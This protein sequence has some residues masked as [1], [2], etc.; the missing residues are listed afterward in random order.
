MS[1]KFNDVE[2]PDLT[3]Y[4]HFIF[5]PSLSSGYYGNFMRKDFK[6]RNG[7]P[8]RYNSEDF[9]ELYRY[10]NFLITA[11]HW[12][13]KATME[14]G[15]PE[16]FGFKTLQSGGKDL[17]MGDS[18]GFQIA[19]GTKPFNQE[20]VEDTY[21]WLNNNVDVAVNLDIPPRLTYLGKFESCLEQSVKNFTYFAEQK[22]RK[23]LFLNVLQGGDWN[24][25]AHWYSKVSGFDFDGWC[26]GSAIGNVKTLFEAF[27]VL[28]EGKEHLNPNNKFVHI[29]GTT[30]PLDMWI[31]AVF[32]LEM[33]KAGFQGVVSI[34]SS[35]PSML[36]AFG[37]TYSNYNWIKES[38]NTVQ[39]SKIDKK[40]IG[41]TTNGNFPV[42]SMFDRY[43]IGG[44]TMQDL[45]LNNEYG[46]AALGL[47]AYA[48]L[49]ETVDF[50][51]YTVSSD[52][53]HALRQCVSAY[54]LLSIIPRIV[55]S[56]NPK[57]ELDRALPVIEKYAPKQSEVQEG[58]I[59]DIFTSLEF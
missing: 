41:E 34:D 39:Y 9:P 44:V 13:G 12:M 20:L 53:V 59:D 6:L 55:H 36:G 19:N 16:K 2:Q 14:G 40:F 56:E 30:K 4:K 11:G 52:S 48:I 22:D 27:T 5:F 54:D 26:I 17:V 58:E 38:F 42:T 50:V 47:H 33:Q 29:L 32:N 25:Y 24:S 23:A 37:R 18:G 21:R 46:W 35:T 45:R 8:C 10:N 28:I 1:K 3:P 51:N 7:L 49:K 15:A 31:A 57:R 43:M